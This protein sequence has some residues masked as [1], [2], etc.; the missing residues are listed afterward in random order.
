[1]HTKDYKILWKEGFQVEGIVCPYTRRKVKRWED[2]PYLCPSCCGEVSAD[3][4]DCGKVFCSS[5]CYDAFQL[6]RGSKIAEKVERRI[7][8]DPGSSEN[9]KGWR[10][11][12]RVLHLSP[13]WCGKPTNETTALKRAELIY[14]WG[15]F[16]TSMTTLF[17]GRPRLLCSG[18]N[19]QA[20]G[21]QQP[22]LRG[23]SVDFLV[24]A[25]NGMVDENI[26]CGSNSVVECQLPK[27]NVASSSLVSRSTFSSKTPRISWD[28]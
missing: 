2:L 13:S 3:R 26:R 10:W 1:M 15:D 5:R 8:Q 20:M 22:A 16:A 12:D 11:R 14:N 6:R 18:W 9:K 19:P 23:I 28:I 25:C 7:L 17:R 21:H 27:L 4:I 24:N